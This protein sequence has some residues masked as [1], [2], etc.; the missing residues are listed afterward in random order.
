M[1]ARTQ[2]IRSE[3]EMNKKTVHTFKAKA[4]ISASLAL[5]LQ[6]KQNWDT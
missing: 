2:E 5:L 1:N 4:Y 6:N 3:G